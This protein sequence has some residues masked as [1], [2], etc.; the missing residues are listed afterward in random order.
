M[1]RRSMRSTMW[2]S[3][4]K[5][6]GFVVC[7]FFFALPPEPEPDL[8]AFGASS[9][10]HDDH[11]AA[12]ACP[13]GV[14]AS[15][16]RLA[17]ALASSVTS[18][19]ISST[20]SASAPRGHHG[21]PDALAAAPRSNSSPRENDWSSR[22]SRRLAPLSETRGARVAD[23]LAS[24]ASVTAPTKRQKSHS[25]ISSFLLRRRQLRTRY[26][27]RASSR[28]AAFPT[29]VSPKN[30][31]ARNAGPMFAFGI[32]N[33]PV[34]FVT[35]AATDRVHASK[36]TFA[37]RTF[38]AFDFEEIPFDF[39]SAARSASS[40]ERSAARFSDRSD[41]SMWNDFAAE[42]VNDVDAR[43]AAFAEEGVPLSPS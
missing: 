15:R 1:R 17:F 18:S 25:G 29:G 8:G 30:P 20:V 38:A 35:V 32:C 11:F 40:A 31:S 39:R 12:C 19:A 42:A 9:P 3:S 23:A 4:S 37:R 2:S 26:T 28:R 14:Y 5:E 7:V 33:A 24:P 6:N 22:T 27:S 34:Q 10:S 43:A 16:A 21:T 36:S 13:I 41:A